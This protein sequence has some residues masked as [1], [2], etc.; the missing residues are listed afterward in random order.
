MRPTGG[1]GSSRRP[2]WRR[3]GSLDGDAVERAAAT[4]L[5]GVD[6]AGLPDTDAAAGR[7]RLRLVRSDCRR[8]IERAAAGR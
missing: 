6:P 3:R 2:S 7:Y 5:D 8:A 1:S 4:A